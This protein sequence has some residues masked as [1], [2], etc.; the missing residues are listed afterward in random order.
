V[1]QES[2]PDPAPS[3]RR[4]HADG[5]EADRLPSQVSPLRVT[6][7][8]AVVNMHCTCG[9]HYRVRVEPLTFWPRNSRR[10]FRAEPT[11]TCV[12]CGADLEE[13]F[14]LQAARLVSSAMIG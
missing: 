12:V 11:T 8:S 2:A 1:G 13:L 5:G 14:G 10:G 4:N 3:S 6:S 7:R 9:Q